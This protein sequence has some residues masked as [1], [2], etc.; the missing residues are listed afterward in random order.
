MRSP[1]KRMQPWR[2]PLVRGQTKE[3]EF[4][5][6]TEKTANKIGRNSGEGGV[7]KVDRGVFQE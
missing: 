7:M 4:V 2:I 1:Q 6:K 3:T 5:K